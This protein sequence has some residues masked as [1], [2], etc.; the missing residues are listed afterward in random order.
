MTKTK[1]IF[2]KKELK[3]EDFL[4]LRSAMEQRPLEKRES[5]KNQISRRNILQSF[6]FMAVVVMLSFIMVSCEKETDN[7]N[8]SSANESGG[9]N[10]GSNTVAPVA[11]FFYSPTTPIAPCTIYLTNNSSGNPTN[12]QWQ[13]GNSTVTSENAIMTVNEPGTYSVKLTVSNSVGSSSIIKNIKVYSDCETNQYGWI[14]FNCTSNNSY[15]LYINNVFQQRLAAH[16]ATTYK[17]DNGTY[18]CRVEQVSGY[19]FYP[20]I[21]TKS[22]NVASCNTVTWTFPSSKSEDN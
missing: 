17:L 2:R 1:S 18:T 16:T 3:S 14:K 5:P 13:L 11:N 15:D 9:S 7:R 22:I 4:S 8:A 10:L 12:F 6:L 21:E 19:I 20:T